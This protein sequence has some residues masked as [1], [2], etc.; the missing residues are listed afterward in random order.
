MKETTGP[1][2]TTAIALCVAI[3]AAGFFG[4]MKYESY[5]TSKNRQ[6]MMGQF[7]GQRPNG[8]SGQFAG[9]RGSGRGVGGN[10][11]VA[12]EILSTDGKTMTVKMVDGSTKIIVLSEKVSINKAS[13]AA[14]EDLKTG[15]KVSVFGTENSDGSLTAV[16]IQLNPVF[17]GMEASPAQK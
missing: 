16:N 10:R 15:E 12:G 4:G 2:S 11:P 9:Q 13:Q 8:A 7:G 6:A 1:I 5:Q 3:G 14:K 17:R